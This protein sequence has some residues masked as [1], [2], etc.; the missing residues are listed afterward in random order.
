MVWRLFSCWGHS[1]SLGDG[2]HSYLTVLSSPEGL[3]VPGGPN[4][5][6]V[7]CPEFSCP[8]GT[9]IDFLLVRVSSMNG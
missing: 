5:T 9:C 7:P 8:N 2:F 3:S 1:C 4:R 6:G